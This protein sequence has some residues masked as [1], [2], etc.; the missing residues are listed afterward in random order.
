MALTHEDKIRIARKYEPVLYFHLGE[1]FFP[2][3]PKVYLEHAAL[4]T[5][6]PAFDQ[7]QNW[8]K[9][10]S[11][12][13]REPILGKNQI[14]A[15]DTA[16]ELQGGRTFLGS[17][18][19]GNSFLVSTKDRELFLDLAGWEDSEDVATGAENRFA[20]LDRV[21]EKY[22]TVPALKSSQNWYYADVMDRQEVSELERFKSLPNFEAFKVMDLLGAYPII[23]VYQFFYP[24]HE[25]PLEGCE[26]WGA[27]KQ[28]SSYAGAWTSVAVFLN[29]ENNP[30][31]IGLS[32]R[33]VSPTDPKDEESR[34]G[35]RALPWSEVD[36]LGG[37][38]KLFVSRGTHGS[39]EKI[40]NHKVFP[41]TSSDFDASTQHC[42]NVE[43]LDEV[44][45]GGGGK[46]EKDADIGILLLKIIPT[47]GLGYFWA[48]AEGA[49]SE[50][51][52][53][54]PSPTNPPEDQAS[55]GTAFKRI[56]APQSLIA[57]GIPEAS[58]AEGEGRD[59]VLPWAAR[60]FE[61]PEARK[62]GFIV[63]RSSEIWW[64]TLIN[65]QGY[66]GRWG[67]RVAHDPK[68]RRA[69]MRMPEFWLLFLRAIAVLKGMP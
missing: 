32:S 12:L 52:T 2:C 6:S 30:Q 18:A 1:R 9:A 3:N 23:V 67:A 21:E 5:A 13:F 47:L 34:V 24:A 51:G 19:D 50:F 33:N 11:A 56:I 66:Q 40:G 35:M 57:A 41:K 58:A 37:H 38:P 28:F 17:K 44:I 53:D 60:E 14:S 45:S 10:S 64:P 20:S 63:S 54:P 4:W 8:G 22:K 26:Y 36:T 48:A 27:G 25:E 46:G 68:T 65:Q 39:Y 7:R 69:G 16:N 49:T 15:M 31:F 62:Y 59:G 55:D 43:D 29:G 42:G 61:S